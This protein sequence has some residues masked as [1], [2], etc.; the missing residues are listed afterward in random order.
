M[1][2]IMSAILPVSLT[3]KAISLSRRAIVSGTLGAVLTMPGP[4]WLRAAE[5][6][7]KAAPTVGAIRWDGWYDRTSVVTQAVTNDLTPSRYHFRLPFFATVG[8]DGSVLIDGASQST[9]DTEIVEASLAHLDYWAFVAYPSD[10]GMSVA[11][12]L[13]L[14]SSQKRRIRFCMFVELANFGEDGTLSPIVLSHLDLMRDPQYFRVAGDRP[15]YYLGFFTAT[16]IIRRW[17]GLDGL[18]RAITDFRGRIDKAGLGN[19]Y[20]VLSGAPALAAGWARLLGLD[21]I[22]AYAI[23]EP[24]PHTYRELAAGLG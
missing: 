9:M 5:P 7:A 2:K 18:R 16:L 6:I 20:M 4:T 14:A 17:G 11:L 3:Q 15:L 22:G 13:Y 23:S 19:P 8:P 24:G 1:Q 12:N 21:A 10:S